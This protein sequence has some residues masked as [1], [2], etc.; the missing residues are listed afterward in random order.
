MAHAVVIDMPTTASATAPSVNGSFGPDREQQRRE[1]RA[2][3]EAGNRSGNGAGDGQH[4]AAGHER[5]DHSGGRCAEGKADGGVAALPANLVIHGGGQP[6]ERD[7]QAGD[8]KDVSSC[9]IIRSREKAASIR[10]SRVRAAP[11]GMPGST[12]NTARRTS[13]ESAVASPDVR[14][15]SCS[16]RLI[17]KNTSPGVWLSGSST[18]GPTVWRGPRSHESSATPTTVQT[19]RPSSPAKAGTANF[20]ARPTTDARRYQSARQRL[21]DDHDRLRIRES[22]MSMSRP[23]RTRMPSVLR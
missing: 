12:L 17:Q 7:R 10:S 1:Q 2:D 14:T 20:T 23:S 3:A 22:V 11:I 8:A 9:A 6:E 15:A 19:L 13:A 4:R 21:V 16:S 18:S 5:R